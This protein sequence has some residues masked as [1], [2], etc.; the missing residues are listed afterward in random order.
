M[1]PAGRQAEQIDWGMSV[2]GKRTGRK[3]DSALSGQFWD[4]RTAYANVSAVPVFPSSASIA[5]S[6]LVIIAFLFG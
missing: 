5:L 3:E 2:S 4:D 1:R 6:R